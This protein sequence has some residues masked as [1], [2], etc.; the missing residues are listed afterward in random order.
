MLPILFL[1][2]FLRSPPPGTK[3]THAYVRIYLGTYG[4]QHVSQ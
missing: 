3:F 4:N 1:V 2:I